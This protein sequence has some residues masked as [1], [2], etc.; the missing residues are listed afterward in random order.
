[1]KSRASH[2]YND[3]GLQKDKSNP[4]KHIIIYAYH[5]LPI[6]ARWS[7]NG[8]LILCSKNQYHKS[9]GIAPF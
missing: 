1:M 8:V 5:E 3:T 7:L 2:F 6:G 9:S 4:L